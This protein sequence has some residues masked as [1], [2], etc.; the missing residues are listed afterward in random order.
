[1]VVTQAVYALEIRRTGLVERIIGRI[2]TPFRND[3]NE[4]DR[5]RYSCCTSL[6]LTRRS[7]N[8]LGLAV[9]LIAHAALQRE[10]DFSIDVRRLLPNSGGTNVGQRSRDSET[11]T[12]VA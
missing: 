5:V 10:G 8:G 11:V 7:V 1:V 2:R 6:R 3:I 4:Q 12:N 9:Q